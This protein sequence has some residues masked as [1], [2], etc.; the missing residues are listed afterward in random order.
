MKRTLIII[1]ILLVV[2]GGVWFTLKPVLGASMVERLQG[3]ILL[4]VEQNGESWYVHPPSQTKFYLGRPTHAFD[5]MRYQGLGIS[6][7][8]LNK[9]PRAGMDD[10]GDINMQQRLSGRILLQVEL[11]GEAWYVYPNDL[12]RYY[13]GR[14]DDAFSIMRELGLGI[15]DN[16]LNQI[17]TDP[18]SMELITD[19]TTPDP[20]P[21]PPEESE[22]LGWVWDETPPVLSN[23]MVNFGTYNA[24]TGKAG[25]YYFEPLLEKVFGEFGRSAQNPDGSPK[26]LAQN[27]YFV[28]A[29]TDIVSPMDAIVNTVTYQES[30]SDYEILVNP[31][32]NSIWLIN[33][34]HIREINPSIVEGATITA[35]QYLGKPSPWFGDSYLVELMITKDLN[36]G[37]P[38]GYCPYDFMTSSLKSIYA[39][40]LNTLM[41]DWETF[42]GDTTI[43]DES[44]HVKPGCLTNT[45]AV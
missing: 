23:F 22:D 20:T 43:Y 42:K 35:G 34:D 14:P 33:F 32:E 11:N 29:D 13:L 30:T 15:T 26:T 40:Y 1:I 41:S 44:S 36:D 37:S 24:G 38:I 3:R 12:K 9:I 31:S 2:I 7:A 5:I 21:A 45:A 10:V 8:D 39:T 18:D 27:D 17:T 28:S 16:D 4:Q 19:D 6:N 25:D